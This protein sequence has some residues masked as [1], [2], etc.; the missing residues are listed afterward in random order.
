MNEGALYKRCHCRD[1]NGRKLGGSCPKLRRPTGAYD[2]KHGAWSLQLE[3]KV[4]A[5]HERT[6]LRSGGYDTR[7]Q[8]QSVLND[9]KTLIALAE[10]ADRPDQAR[11][12]IAG[13]IQEALRERRPLPDADELRARLRLGR[14]VEQHLTVEVFLREWLE[15]KRGS[16]TAST[17]TSYR[18]YCEHHLIPAL[19]HL[20]LT[21]LRKHHVQQ[22]LDDIAADAALIEAQN[23]ERRELQAAAKAAYH[24]KDH[25]RARQL[26]ARL[27]LMPP[28]R[29][30]P[31]PVTLQRIRAT[32]RSALTSAM[33]EELVTVN[34]AKLVELP[35][36]RRARPMLW[37][38]P[39]VRQ[40]RRTGE[41]PS[42]VMVWT[43][44][45]TRAFLAHAEN[46]ELH[47]YYVLVAHLGLRRGEAAGLRWSDIDFRTG[48]IGI[49]RQIIQVNWTPQVTPTKTAAGERTVIAPKPVLT[50]LARHR[51]RQRTWAAKAGDEWNDAGWV[52]TDHYGDHL[53]PDQFL[54]CFQ[55]LTKQAGLPPVRLHDLRHGAATLARAAG[56]DLKT[57]SAM[58]GHSSVTITADIYTSVV[59]EA[60]REAADLIADLLAAEHNDEEDTHPDPDETA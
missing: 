35:A 40:W 19:G 45:H 29:H 49:D 53:T 39:R 13:L 59:D 6:H 8:A 42:P 47:A 56:V 24:V 48:T 52:F 9:I 21:K 27:A 10:T 50:A 22:L 12:Q 5:G 1:E 3:V 33:K 14:P 43:A 51:R 41:I 54:T 18:I 32:L 15:T 23:T 20:Q 25:A 16:R 58:L 37:T 2:S 57:V 30:V 17:Y 44:P 60:K 34:V 36:H 4:P 11:L 28:L 7:D 31:G 38:E 55:A 46:H 26:R